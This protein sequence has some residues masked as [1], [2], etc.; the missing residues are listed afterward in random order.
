MLWVASYSCAHTCKNLIGIISPNWSRKCIFAL[1]VMKIEL[2]MITR[3]QLKS[4]LY[5]LSKWC[6]MHIILRAAEVEFNQCLL[7]SSYFF[8]CYSLALWFCWVIICFLFFVP[9]ASLF[10]NYF[11]VQDEAHSV[12]KWL[13]CFLFLNQKLL[14]QKKVIR[15]NLP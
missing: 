11:I 10:Y 13:F 3:L 14:L 9:L 6:G 2:I 1:R 4:F 12:L 8:D 5:C 7:F 15:T